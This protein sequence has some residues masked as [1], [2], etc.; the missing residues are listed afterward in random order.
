MRIK[1][2]QN[3]IDM[4][5]GKRS[6]NIFIGGFK[7]FEEALEKCN[8]G[9]SAQNILDKTLESI[10]KVKNGE[11][12]FER[13]SKLSD[14]P[15]YS[16]TMLSALLKVAID[17][18]NQLNI[19][20]FG[21]SLGSHYFQNKEILKPIQI[22]N[23]TVVEQPHYVKIGNE[24]V[25]DD[26]LNFKNNIEDVQNANV[27]I[28][29]NVLQ[30][31]PRPY[32]WMEKFVNTNIKYILI[33]RT[34]FAKKDDK[35]FVQVVPKSFYEAKYPIWFL[36]EDKIKDIFNKKYEIVFEYEAPDSKEFSKHAQHIMSYFLKRIDNK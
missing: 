28:L 7:T 18:N 11:A 29:S 35:L 10:L 17:N 8:K 4:L 21:G 5:R 12:I 6:K 33:D 23:W 32:E 34:P 15:L 9:Y 20:D 24:K 22:T 27:L 25:A 36:N 2:I 16:F 30:Y 13:D 3:F 31:L 19:L 1:I 14:I 26:I